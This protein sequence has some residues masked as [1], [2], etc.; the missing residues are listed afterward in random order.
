MKWKVFA[1][2]AVG[3]AVFVGL[4]AARA[5]F[6]DQPPLAPVY[7][8]ETVGANRAIPTDVGCG[9]GGSG[10]SLTGVTD[11][12][13]IV[14]CSD[15][16]AFDAG[17]V[18]HFYSYF[19][20]P[21]VGVWAKAQSSNDFTVGGGILLPDAGAPPSMGPELTVGYPF[22]RFIYVSSGVGCVGASWDGGITSTLSRAQK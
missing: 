13:A 12:H 8:T 22:G 1:P 16:S 18:G 21:G 10:A 6:A 3:V 5:A 2:I 9:V 4:A 19:C 17:V 15:N 11:M 20:D 14:Q 7:F